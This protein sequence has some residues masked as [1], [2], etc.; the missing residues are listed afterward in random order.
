MFHCRRQLHRWAAGLLLV[1]LFGVAAGV[2]NA[3]LTTTMAELGGQRSRPTQAAGEAHGETAAAELHHDSHQAPHHGA[4][5]H[6]ASPAQ[7]NCQDHCDKSTVSIPPLKSALD[8]TLGHA[9]PPVAIVMACPAQDRAPAKRPM[10]RRAGA[11]APPITIAFLRL[12]L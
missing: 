3:C 4:L 7:F 12:A 6:E 1:W 2:A 5:G 10:P 11:L 8:E 9:L